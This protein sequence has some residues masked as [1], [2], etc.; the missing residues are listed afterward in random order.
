MYYIY[1]SQYDGY[2]N[3]AQRT[4]GMKTAETLPEAGKI[5][6]EIKEKELCFLSYIIKG[7]MVN[8]EIENKTEYK[9][10]QR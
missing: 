7:E 2:D 10:T 4:E 1:Y 6:E 3:Y 9:E 8:I 5:V